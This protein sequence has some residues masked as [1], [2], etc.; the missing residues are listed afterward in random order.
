MTLPV[1]SLYDLLCSRRAHSPVLPRGVQL[2]EFKV[3]PFACYVKPWEKLVVVEG[4]H[5][6]LPGEISHGL[7]DLLGHGLGVLLDGKDSELHAVTSQ[8][9]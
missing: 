8:G 7:C 2:F 1:H 6:N 3:P 5:L 9:L 4:T